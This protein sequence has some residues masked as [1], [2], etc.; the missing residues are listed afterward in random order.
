MAT[1]ASMTQSPNAMRWTKDPVLDVQHLT[2]RFGGLV[3]V[4][5]LS[6]QA[7]RGDIT[8]LIGPN[9]AG[10]TTVFNCITGFY[11]P[12]EGM[13]RLRKTGGSDLL[14]ERLPGHS[15]NWKAK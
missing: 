1:S 10:K 2:M 12:T 7:G 11:K 15:I 9:G 14:L 5:D 6:F 4:N 8:A 13:I 3:A